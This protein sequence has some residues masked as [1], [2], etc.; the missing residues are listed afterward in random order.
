MAQNP[1]HFTLQVVAGY[2]ESTVLTFIARKN[3]PRSELA[4][5][6]SLNRGK[7]WHSLL[8]GSYPNRDQAK[9]AAVELGKQLKHIKPWIRTFKSV[10]GD[11]LYARSRSQ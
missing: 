1:D 7:G 3:L 6:Y 4:Y 10:Q 11:I 9:G 2:Q 5:Y 8:F